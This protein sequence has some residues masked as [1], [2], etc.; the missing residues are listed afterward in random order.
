MLL[1]TEGWHRCA[2]DSS[3]I[4]RSEAEGVTVK[5]YFPWSAQ[6]SLEWIW[7][8]ATDLESSTSTSTLGLTPKMSAEWF[9]ETEEQNAV[10]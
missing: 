5:G 10:A 1:R 2:R 3:Q 6:N 4:D 9:G 8:T 7:G